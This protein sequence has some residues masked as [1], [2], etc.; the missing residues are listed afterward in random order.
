MGK[1]RYNEKYRDFSSGSSY[2]SLVAA[3]N[4]SR[5]AVYIG[6]TQFGARAYADN[7][8]AENMLQAI[9]YVHIHDKKSI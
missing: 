6:G 1:W 3:I 4:A 9:D 8:E 5:D 2:E 7:L